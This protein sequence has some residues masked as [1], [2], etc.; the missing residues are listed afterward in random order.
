MQ[1]ILGSYFAD[2]LIFIILSLLY[3]HG[4]TLPNLNFWFAPHPADYYEKFW[5]DEHVRCVSQL[6]VI[7]FFVFAVNVSYKF[8]KLS[9]AGRINP[10]SLLT[11][12]SGTGWPSFAT[13]IIWVAI[14]VAG[15]CSVVVFTYPAEMWPSSGFGFC[16]ALK[17]KTRAFERADGGDSRLDFRE[18]CAYVRRLRDDD[19][20]PDSKLRWNFM[21]I[22]KDRSGFVDVQEYI[23]WAK[24]AT[25]DR[26]TFTEAN[27][28]SAELTPKQT[29]RTSSRCL[30]AAELVLRF[31]CPPYGIVMLC[32]EERQKGKSA[33][34]QLRGSAYLW[35]L[36]CIT[37]EAG[38][39]IS[40]VACP[41]KPGTS[42]QNLVLA[43]VLADTFFIVV[44][45]VIVGT[46]AIIIRS[47]ILS[48]AARKATGTPHKMYLAAL[49]AVKAMRQEVNAVSIQAWFRGMRARKALYIEKRDKQRAAAR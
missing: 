15:N 18:F 13:S 8:V 36:L 26:K 9:D 17:R 40:M 23:A 46:F 30:A 3:M 33:I 39:V 42:P 34:Q 14:E 10:N 5:N 49:S 2:G 28:F 38:F 16:P 47:S 7:T 25:L 24:L 4:C 48:A 21:T 29:R 19:T 6:Q 37:S 31:V 1:W 43:G 20:I 11:Q 12:L 44:G 45:I 27:L 35:G 22:D 41:H 32:C